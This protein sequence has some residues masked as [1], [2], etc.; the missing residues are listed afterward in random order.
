MINTIS[1][2]FFAF[3]AHEMIKFIKF[4]IFPQLIIILIIMHETAD[5]TSLST[6]YYYYLKKCMVCGPAIKTVEHTA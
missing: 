5:K 6:F 4:V 3:C 1:R 2:E